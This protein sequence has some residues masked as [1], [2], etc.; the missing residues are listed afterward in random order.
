MDS[1]VRNYALCIMLSVVLLILGMVLYV[2]RENLPR[3][4]SVS[5]QMPQEQM[6]QTK[7]PEDEPYG[8]GLSREQL[9]AFLLD[10]TFFDADSVFAETSSRQEKPRL[11][12][13]AS[14]MEKD[15]RVTVVDEDGAVV[16][17]HSFYVNLGES[18]YKDLDQ[19]GII[20]IPELTAGDYFVSLEP[21]LGYEVPFDPMHVYVKEQLEYSVIEDISYLIHSEDEIDVAKEDLTEAVLFEEDQDETEN[22]ALVMEEGKLF[23]IDVSKWQHEIDWQKVAA[24]GVEFA[25]IRCGY[26]GASTGCLVEDPYFRQNIEGAKAAG[27]KVGVYFFTQAINEVEAVEE[28]SMVA[29]LCKDY[30]LDFPVFIDVEGMGGNGRADTLGVDARTSVV[31]AFCDTI[32]EV[33]YL[34]GVYSSRWWYNNMLEDERLTDYVLWNAEYRAEPLYDGD[35]KIWQYTSNGYIDGIHTRVDLN[36]SSVD[37]KVAD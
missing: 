10:E 7:M 4:A 2:N 15:I 1:K 21:V 9:Q 17:G 26:R 24:S 11:Y 35:F 32:Q 16:K 23:G 22:T 25:I 29:T 36:I 3:Q 37:F 33:G 6:Q 8:P 18:Q 19:D 5:G 12:L 30:R 31:E 14:S 34:P 20:Y 28:A 27:L 13:L